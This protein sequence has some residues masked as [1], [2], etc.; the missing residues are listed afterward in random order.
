MPRRARVSVGNFVYHCINRSNGRQKIFSTDKD[1]EHFISLLLEAKDLIDMRI[2][3]YCVMPNHWHLLLYPKNENDMGEF[4]RWVTTTHVRQ[5]RVLTKTV[6]Y[7]H[8]YKDAYKSFLVEK[9]EYLRWVIRYIEQNPLR[10]GLVKRAEDWKWSSLYVREKESEKKKKLLSNS[11][12]ALEKNYLHSVNTII[13]KDDLEKIRYSVNKGK[14]YG[15]DKWSNYMIEKYDLKS[16]IRGAGR[17]KK[18]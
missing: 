18:N 14:P 17:P 8:L 11:P 13:K 1:Y 4:M 3:A 12:I 10:A 2:L 5:R 6:G 7:G 15:S 9:D 16:T